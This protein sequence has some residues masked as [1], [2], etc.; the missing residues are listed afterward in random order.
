MLARAVSESTCCGRR[1]VSATAAATSSAKPA[2]AT[3]RQVSSGGSRRSGSSSSTTCPRSTACTPSTS[4]WCT[5]VTR[6]KRFA[7]E[8]LDDVDL[9]QRAGAVQAAGLDA[10]DQLLELLLRAG[11]R[12]RLPPHVVGQ[13]EP[14][15]VDPD[16]V[17]DPAGHE[18]DTLPVAGDERDPGLEMAKQPR[19]V[20]AG[21]PGP[22]DHD[23]A[24]VHGCRPL[25]QVEEGDVQ[26][27]QP[28][29][30]RDTSSPAS[31]QERS[32]HA[33]RVS[34]RAHEPTMPHTGAAH[35][36]DSGDPDHPAAAAS[37]SRPG[38]RGH[39]RGG[40]GAGRLRG[41]RVELDVRLRP[42]PAAAKSVSRSR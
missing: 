22:E 35:P 29:R 6:A 23:R 30:H 20:Q 32:C 19:V 33:P 38:R 8:A 4:A 7:F 1:S 17:G 24:D 16:R 13:V 36:E 14:L 26:R 9:P 34:C 2:P 28:V 31:Q 5:L 3:G 27:R 39:G 11:G 18:P 40:A 12:Q 42:R 21:V 15:V 25:L 41:C 10:G 37:R